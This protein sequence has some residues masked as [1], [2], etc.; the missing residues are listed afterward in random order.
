MRKVGLIFL[1]VAVCEFTYLYRITRQ[2]EAL[3]I[4]TSDN[5]QIEN[6]NISENDQK[7]IQKLIPQIN[8]QL[9]LSSLFVDLKKSPDEVITKENA[10]EVITIANANI[11][12]LLICAIRHNCEVSD[13]ATQSYLEHH[14][15][16]LKIALR[17]DPTQASAVNW[18]LVRQ[19]SGINNSHVKIISTDLLRNYDPRNNGTE[20][21]FKI[22]E[23]Y[24]GKDKVTFFIQMSEALISE[25]RGVFISTLKESLRKDSA[26]NVELL[27]KNFKD[28]SLKQRELVDLQKDLCHFKGTNIWS[29]IREN[30]LKISGEF[31]RACL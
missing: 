31:D 18:I 14:L 11:S 21:F 20:Q 2:T 15:D 10:K 27:V 28:M 12:I 8:N 6:I 13:V 7:I 19:S 30:M 16:I 4:Q 29:S 3:K 5:I 22:A 17:H 1:F 9:L 23:T 24:K 26:A 25:E